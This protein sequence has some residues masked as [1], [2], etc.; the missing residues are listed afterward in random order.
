MNNMHTYPEIEIFADTNA[1]AQAATC[2]FRTVARRTIATRG[3]FLVALSGGTTP[4]GLYRNL[5]TETV[6]ASLDWSLVHIFWGDERS[7]PPD[8]PDSNFKMAYEALL[9]RVPIP[10]ENI[11]RI[12][13]EKPPHQAAAEYEAL[14]RRFFPPETPATFDLVLLGMGADG[15]TA[16]LFPM[17]ASDVTAEPPE[18]ASPWVATTYVAQMDAWRITLTP[19]AINAAGHIIFLVA[20]RNKAQTVQDVLTGPYRPQQL[21]SQLIRPQNGKLTWMMDAAAG[22]LLPEPVSPVEN[23]CSPVWEKNDA[24]AEIHA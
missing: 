17:T 22:R 6:D 10:M 3:R 23:A 11:H 20:G 9:R 13:G 24:R 19:T 5:A 2:R 4:Y 8:H 15:H 14:L 16:S 7:V 18:D 21:P 1:L 12:P